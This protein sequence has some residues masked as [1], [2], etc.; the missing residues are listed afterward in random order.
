[1]TD[2]SAVSATGDDKLPS[3]L[4]LQKSMT[5]KFKEIDYDAQVPAL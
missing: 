2:V 3:V 5:K 1:M 4:S